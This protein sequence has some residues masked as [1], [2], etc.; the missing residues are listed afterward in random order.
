[1]LGQFLEVS[2]PVDAPDEALGQLRA[3]GFVE[4]ET[5]ERAGAPYAVVWDGRATIGLHAGDDTVPTLTFVRRDL[6]AYL[7][8]FRRGGVELAFTRLAEDEFHQAGIDD[9]NGQRIVLNEARTFS[10]G[11]WQPELVPACGE[12][13]E[14]SLATGVLD[15]S[16]AFWERIGLAVAESGEA[17]H[18]W[19][20]LTG[21]GLALG[22]HERAAFAPGLTFRAASFDARCDY[23]RAL[24]LTVSPGAPV[25]LDTEQAA[26]LATPFPLAI[27]LVGETR[28]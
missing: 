28:A 11:V 25:A 16:V 23:L 13:V 7:H 3:L 19:A 22:L 18:R 27:Y 9:P 1:M 8:A 20:R 17:P 2:V 14:Y 6:E 15:E 10:P 26:T 21:N 12:L 4:L 24:G 5:I